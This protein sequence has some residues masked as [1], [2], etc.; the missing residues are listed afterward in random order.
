MIFIL[1][2]TV[3]G[4]FFMSKRIKESYNVYEIIK[5]R[6]KEEKQ[7][8]CVRSSWL[9]TSSFATICFVGMAMMYINIENPQ[10]VGLSILIVLISIGECINAITIR[11]FYYDQHGF[12]YYQV[13]FRYQDINTMNMNTSVFGLSMYYINM[14]SGDNFTL[15]KGAY[16]I[17][18]AKY[19]GKSK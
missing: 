5:A 13:Y 17:L 1:L 8:Y 19:K 6:M 9:H 15:H 10:M 14:K 4:I 2:F 12:Y 11:Y 16:A 7:L 3:I 18:K